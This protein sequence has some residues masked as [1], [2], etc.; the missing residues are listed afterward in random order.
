MSKRWNIK[1]ERT[2][3]GFISTLI[4]SFVTSRYDFVKYLCIHS[5]W[6]ELVLRHCLCSC[7]L[8]PNGGY[9]MVRYIDVHLA[10]ELSSTWYNTRSNKQEERIFSSNRL[11]CTTSFDS[12]DYGV[13]P[14]RWQQHDRNMFRGLR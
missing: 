6:R 7:V 13:R 5:Q 10:Y 2:E 11:V 8:F 12:R 9:G 3:V 14:N 4:I 1:D